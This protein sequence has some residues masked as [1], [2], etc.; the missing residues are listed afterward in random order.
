M[1]RGRNASKISHD[2]Q[3]FRLPEFVLQLVLAIMYRCEGNLEPE[4]AG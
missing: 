3:A 2:C 4:T 1:Q